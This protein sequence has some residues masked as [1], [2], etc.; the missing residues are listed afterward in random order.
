MYERDY[1]ALKKEL[2]PEEPQQ[3]TPSAVNVEDIKT[4]LSLYGGLDRA[5]KKE[6]W[7]RTIKRIVANNDGNFF[8]ELI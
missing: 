6:F 1:L 4:A 2:E 7:N 8:V 3:D 5:G